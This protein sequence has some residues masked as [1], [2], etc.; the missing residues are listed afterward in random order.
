MSVTGPDLADPAGRD[1]APGGLPWLR[2]SAVAVAVLTVGIGALFGAR[3]NTDNTVV[4]TPLIG[5]TAST[6]RL[7]FLEKPGEFSLADLRGRVV[8]VNF[9]AS[10]C[11]ACREEHPA[12]LAT[13]AAYRSRGVRFVGVDFQ[14]Q[15]GSAT[16][17]LDEMGR[18][19]DYTYVADTGSRLAVDFGVFGVPETFFLDKKGT[20]VG[21]ITGP[22][23]VPLLSRTIE[24]ILAGGTPR[25]STG[26]GPVQPGK[27][28]P[29]QP[30][31]GS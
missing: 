5:T 19:K 13:A 27:D 25:P 7:P 1:A 26:T 8:V 20:I 24:S 9:W 14:D 4:D 12:L 29:L 2:Y 21:K 31:A 17:F 10:W 3:L 30:G 22:S 18:G 6:R 15:R 11:V 16:A 23:T 28:R